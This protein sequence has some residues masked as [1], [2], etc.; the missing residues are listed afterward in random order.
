M[1]K[2][3]TTA[4]AAFIAGLTIGGGGTYELTDTEYADNATFVE[5]QDSVDA[6]DGTVLRPRLKEQL[7]ILDS[8][9]VVRVLA[10]V[11]GEV[12]TEIKREVTIGN[13]TDND[14]FLAC[15]KLDI[16]EDRSNVPDPDFELDIV[17]TNEVVI[18]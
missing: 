6:G 10:F 16:R 14:K 7:P 17:T 9:D 11:N 5:A 13:R 12:V 4:V 8:G 18:P 3:K 15:L 1:A 2:T